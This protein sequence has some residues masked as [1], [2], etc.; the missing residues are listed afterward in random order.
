MFQVKPDLSTFLTAQGIELRHKGRDL[1]GLCP[2]HGEQSPSFKVDPTKQRF[3]CFGCGESGDVID[4]AQKLLGL[5]FKEAL[6]Y[7]N[8]KDLALQPSPREMKKRQLVNRFRAW[9]R[10]RYREQA[11]F[12]RCIHLLLSEFGTMD[13]VQ[14]YSF[15][16]YQL[17]T[18]EHEMDILQFGSDEEKFGLY[19]AHNAKP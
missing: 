16:I 10:N 17:P 6:D 1:W 2:F 7:L 4:A 5:S 3:H 18:L 13:E 15:L 11:D 14:R 9:C 12:Y 19:Q 8:M